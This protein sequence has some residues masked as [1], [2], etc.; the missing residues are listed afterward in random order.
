MGV[1]VVKGE[2]ALMAWAARTVAGERGKPAEGGAHL[3]EVAAGKVGTSAGRGEEG[4]AGKEAASGIETDGAGGMAGRMED[5]ESSTG[6]GDDIAL[7]EKNVGADGGIETAV[8][9]GG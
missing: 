5:G 9:K 8:H 1:G 2:A 3:P 7:M 4:I 6:G